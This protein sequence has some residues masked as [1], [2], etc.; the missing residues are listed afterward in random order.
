MAGY[1]DAI[2]F[3]MT[4]GYFVSF[5]S[6]NSTRFGVSVFRHAS[7]AVTA[8]G[9]VVAFVCGVMAGAFLRRTAGRRRPQSAVLLL[10][11]LLLLAAA[12]LAAEARMRAAALTLA[13]AMGAENT[14]FAETGDVRVGLTY[15]TG[16]L[17]KAAKGLVAALFGGDRLGWALHLLLWLSLVVGVIAGASVY[18][19]L[20]LAALWWAAGAMAGLGVLSWWWFPSMNDPAGEP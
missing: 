4:G 7:E 16:A 3:L 13:L 15:M 20:G 11:V 18:G 6:G 12:W 8:A 2:G 10:L 9:L 19:A 5:M 1:V 17:V 14:I